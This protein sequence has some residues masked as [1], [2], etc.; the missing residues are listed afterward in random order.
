MLFLEQSVDLGPVALDHRLLF[1][2]LDAA[3]Q[4]TVGAC[5]FVCGGGAVWSCE[6]AAASGV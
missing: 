5:V 2:A 6:L 4:L 3:S 1:Q